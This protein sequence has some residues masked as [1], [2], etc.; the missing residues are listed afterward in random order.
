LTLTDARERPEADIGFVAYL[1]DT[2][3]ADRPA[4]FVVNGGPGASSAYLHLG[5]LGPW[6]LPMG[7]VVPSQAVDLVPNPD[8]WLDFTDLVFVDPV[9]TGFS[10][11][12][13]PDDRLRARYLSIEGDVEAMSAFVFRWLTDNGRVRSPK[14]FV[15]ESYGGFRGP[16]IADE[17]QTEFGVGLSG[18]VLVSPVLDFGW[19]SQPE[20]GPL[21]RASLLPSLAAA[22]ME[23][24]DAFSPEALQ[25]VEDYA[26]G[27][28]VTDLLRGVG[29]EAASARIAAR[30]AEITGLGPEV[31]D[32]YE[33][34]IDAHEFQ[35]E[36]FRDERRVASS[37]DA[38]V[39]GDPRPG[40]GSDPLLAAMTAP[41]TGAM[42]AF[43]ED[44]LHW[45]PARRYILLNRE[46]NRAWD[47]GDGRGQAEAVRPLREV[48]ALD[49]D[50]RLL[51]VHGYTDL[52]TPYF[53]TE[54]IL[55]QLPEFGGRV[56]QANYRGGHMF[57]VRDESRRAFRADALALYGGGSG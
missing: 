9:G 29:D 56:Q 48:L 42:L 22:G 44:T 47:W 53:G 50:F 34:R 33:G 18:M 39:P 43:Y 15:G 16:L 2:D 57:Y 27:D 3:D 31:I 19:W 11:L 21:A 12:V 25:A 35:S 23:K 26:A 36:I 6:R 8:T 51:V 40:R 24:R 5:A 52:V 17:L 32:R 1:R 37:Y 28:Y 4:T 46:V 20:D 14:Y 38:A 7:D 13:D 10:R 49:R 55:R 54:L 41:L 45:L 30:V